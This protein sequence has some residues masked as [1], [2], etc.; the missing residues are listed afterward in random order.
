MFLCISTVSACTVK[1]TPHLYST[2]AFSE[3][4]QLHLLTSPA[5]SPTCRL[6]ADRVTPFCDICPVKYQEAG[7]TNAPQTGGNLPLKNTVSCFEQRW[8]QTRKSILGGNLQ[9]LLSHPITHIHLASLHFYI[10]QSDLET[11]K[12]RSPLV[13]QIYTTLSNWS[14]IKEVLNL[15]WSEDPPGQWVN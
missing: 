2:S 10:H 6:N 14:L 7:N 4:S 9:R 3:R 5:S 15:G 12:T 13:L 11:L 8:S 1:Q